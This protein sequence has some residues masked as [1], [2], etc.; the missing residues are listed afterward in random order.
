GTQIGNIK[1]AAGAGTH[2]RVIP[3]AQAAI[4][5]IGHLP[6][7]CTLTNITQRELET[8]MEG[9]M[10][11]W[12][13][14]EFATSDIAGAC[15][16]PIK[17]VV[18]KDVSGTSY[19]LKHFLFINNEASLECIGETWEELQSAAKNTSWPEGCGLTEVVKPAGNGGGEVAETVNADSG[20][21]GY[22]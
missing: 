6:A 2:L 13:D 1:T 12:S 22:V 18:R 10:F 3:V 8:A 17:R 9:S 21:I 7:G 20:T 11:T 15:N 16:V 4:A 19:Q 5:I 14:F